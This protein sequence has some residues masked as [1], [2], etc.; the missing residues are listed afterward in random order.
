[1]DNWWLYRKFV[2]ILSLAVILMAG[3]T[4]QYNTKVQQKNYDDID[5]VRLATFSGLSSVQQPEQVQIS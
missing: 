1:M 4:Q 5:N 2:L 3:C